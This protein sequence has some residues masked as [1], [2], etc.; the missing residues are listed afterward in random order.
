VRRIGVFPIDDVVRFVIPDF[1]N[2]QQFGNGSVGNAAY[3]LFN[4]FR[5]GSHSG[6]GM[7]GPPQSF[8]Q[9]WR[10]LSRERETKSSGHPVSGIRFIRWV[11]KNFPTLLTMPATMLQRTG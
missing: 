6:M 10:T 7:E 5:S 2:C 9:R 3:V 1:A 8:G 11:H 4:Q